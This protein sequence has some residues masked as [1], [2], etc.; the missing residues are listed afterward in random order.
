MTPR[1]ASVAIIG[2]GDFI[3][4]AIAKKFAAEGFTIFAGRRNA[5]KLAQPPS[6]CDAEMAGQSGHA[7][8]AAVDH[9]H[10]CTPAW[11]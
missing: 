4:S 1:N 9:R 7:V 8:K 5:D 11:E 10:R 6:Q 2:A 3:G